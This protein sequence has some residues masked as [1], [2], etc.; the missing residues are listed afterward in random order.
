MHAHTLLPEL[1]LPSLF[2]RQ[3]LVLNFPLPIQVRA[4]ALKLRNE[5][6]NASIALIVLAFAPVQM[7]VV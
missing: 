5:S 1:H 7:E 4:F 3:M 2:Y 6:S